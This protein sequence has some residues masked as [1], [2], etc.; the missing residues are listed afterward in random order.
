MKTIG[1]SD[2]MVL[3]RLFRAVPIRPDDVLVDIGCG[4][5]RVI[6]WWLKLGKDNRI[7]GVEYDPDTA[8][9]TRTRLLPYKNVEVMQGDAIALV[10]SEATYLY[11]FNPFDDELMARFLAALKERI[12][13]KSKL[14]IIYY[15][16]LYLDVIKND[17]YWQV[18]EHK[19]NLGLRYRDSYLE[20]AVITVAC[21]A[22]S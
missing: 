20:Y 16:P 2:Y 18:Q 4:K 5:G 22:Q 21:S 11:L 15:R 13:D 8:Q 14:R 3:K 1:N 17:S 9:K 10:P 12:A 7:I 6:N 19:L